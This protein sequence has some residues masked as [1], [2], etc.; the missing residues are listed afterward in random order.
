MLDKDYF[1]LFAFSENS[2]SKVNYFK[3][4]YHQI[5]ILHHKCLE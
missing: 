4:S 1:N 3:K 5:C 2:S